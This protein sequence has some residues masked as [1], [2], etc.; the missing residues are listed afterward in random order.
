MKNFENVELPQDKFGLHQTCTIYCALVALIACV[1][2]W[3]FKKNRV[4]SYYGRTLSL[5]PAVYGTSARV[6][7][8]V[9]DLHGFV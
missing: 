8:R 2:G 4:R 3:S 7:R 6:N 9:M 5:I 1:F